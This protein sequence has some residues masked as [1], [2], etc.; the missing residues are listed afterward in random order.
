MPLLAVQ[1]ALER[2]RAKSPALGLS[3]QGERGRKVGD[4][5]DPW[6]L[7]EASRG[8]DGY[9]HR[10]LVGFQQDPGIDWLGGARR[11]AV[12]LAPDL[13]RADEARVA[14]PHAGL[15]AELERPPPA[16]DG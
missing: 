12:D 14:A 5:H 1:V 11:E 8:S 9:A 2:A 13:L 6:R 4:A 7:S 15:V 16:K 3:H 10:R